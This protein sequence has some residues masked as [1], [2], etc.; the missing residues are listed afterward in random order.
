MTNPVVDP[1]GKER[2]D[3]G[4]TTV[5]VWKWPHTGETE[6]QITSISDK[7]KR[8]GNGYLVISLPGAAQL[9]RELTEMLRRR[10]V[11]V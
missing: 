4:E 2:W 8:Q 1:D 9:H 7:A 10:G 3:A 11:L 6:V 5:T